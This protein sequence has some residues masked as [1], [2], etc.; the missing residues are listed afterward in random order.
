MAEA[1]VPEAE[2]TLAPPNYEP[3]SDVW[4]ETLE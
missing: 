3:G 2:A 4:Q 1:R